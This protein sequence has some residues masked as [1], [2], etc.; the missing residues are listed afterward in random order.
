MSYSPYDNPPQ[1]TSKPTKQ[2]NTLGFLMGLIILGLLAFVYAHQ[3]GLIEPQSQDQQKQVIDD[4]VIDDSAEDKATVDKPA[5]EDTYVVR[6][7]ET[8]ADKEL[9]LTKQVNNEQFWI[10]WIA[11]QGM[12]MHTLDPIDGDGN[13][14]PQASSFV[15]AAKD[16][17]IA[18]PFWMHVRNGGTVLT[19]TQYKESVDEDTWKTIIKNSV[20]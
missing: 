3:T 14:N 11:E 1:Q 15:R 17:G 20:K 5:I 13:D 4:S 8:A 12:K 9:W 16:R 19:V 7:F 10:K 6:V 2:N 18:S